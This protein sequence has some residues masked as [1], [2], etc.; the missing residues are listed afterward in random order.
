MSNEILNCCTPV[1]E[2]HLSK[3]FNDCLKIGIFP[4]CLIIANGIPLHKK[5]DYSHPE[6]Y[7]PV[8]LLSSLSNVFEKL[9]YNR[10]THFFVRYHLF[11]PV[12]FSFLSN[13]S[14]VHAIVDITQYT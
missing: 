5:S 11:T 6:I 9:L 8:S 2:E 7:H 10:M 12:Q 3:A 14:Y 13:Y 4:E 1:V